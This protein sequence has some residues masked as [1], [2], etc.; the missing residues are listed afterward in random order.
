MSHHEIH[1]AIQGTISADK[2][3][4]QEVR[5]IVKGEGYQYSVH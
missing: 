1:I 4:V 5:E 2:L 3:T